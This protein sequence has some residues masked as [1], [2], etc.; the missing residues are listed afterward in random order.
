MESLHRLLAAYFDAPRRS[1]IVLLLRQLELT[2]LVDTALRLLSKKE[3]QFTDIVAILSAI[4]LEMGHKLDHLKSITEDRRKL[5][6][7]STFMFVLLGDFL[8]KTPQ[9]PRLILTRLRQNLALYRDLFGQRKERLPTLFDFDRLMV[10][11]SAR[12]KDDAPILTSAGERSARFIWTD[13]GKLEEL[14]HQLL[15]RKLIHRKSELFDLFLRPNDNLTIQWDGHR[16]PELS[17][18]LF[19][20]YSLGYLRISGNKGY[21]A[22]A[23][24]HFRGIDGTIIKKNSL[25]KLSSTIRA[26]NTRYNTVIA[27]V[28][29]IIRS[30]SLAD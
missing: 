6:L 15:K 28:D 20:L 26:E 9:E 1:E 7:L 29:E 11:C 18:L 25:K 14:V 13:K 27:E 21:F 16:M 5:D 10:I 4:L 3:N 2:T 12:R 23:E 19:R 8:N 24:R 30:I 22:L 17:Y